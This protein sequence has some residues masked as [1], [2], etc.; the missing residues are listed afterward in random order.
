MGWFQQLTGIN[1]DSYFQNLGMRTTR[2]RHSTGKELNPRPL[3]SYQGYQG[4]SDL[5][6]EL[7]D[8]ESLPTWQVSIPRDTL[9]KAFGT[10]TIAQSRFAPNQRWQINDS[11][12][13]WVNYR[14]F[15]TANISA[16]GDRI[17]VTFKGMGF[18]DVVS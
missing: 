5:G 17:E 11:G 16:E 8:S 13:G 2:L 9:I 18:E 15:G 10:W 7:E 6:G 14:V 1:S 3:L 12:Q 4:T